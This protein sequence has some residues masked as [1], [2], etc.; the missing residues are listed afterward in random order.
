[1]LSSTELNGQKRRVLQSV[2]VATPL[3]LQFVLLSSQMRTYFGYI[4]AARIVG[5][6]VP[7]HDAGGRLDRV[8]LSCDWASKLDM[9]EVPGVKS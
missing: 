6:A 4:D 5:N 3:C 7:T 8:W 1:M 9:F 2:L